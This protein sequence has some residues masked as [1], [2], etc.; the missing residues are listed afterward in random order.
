[1]NISDF[2]NAAYA[3]LSKGDTIILCFVVD[4][5]KGSPGTSAARMFVDVSG[6]ICGTI[7]GG[8]M[9]RRVIDRCVENLKEDNL[10]EPTLHLLEHRA[11]SESKSSGLICGGSQTNLEIALTPK[12]DLELVRSI[13]ESAS[14]GFGSL[15]CTADNL[16]LIDEVV[17][18]TVLDKGDKLNERWVVKIPLSNNRR[19]VVFGGG[20]CGVALC[21]TM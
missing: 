8:I 16:E 14:S 17:K 1:M 5:T 20:H 12:R 7:G 19:V 21:N 11:K 13:S 6:R 18:K 15:R 3:A 2:W 10:P 4:Q 9:E